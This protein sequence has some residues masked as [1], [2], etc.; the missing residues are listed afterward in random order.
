MCEG[1]LDMVWGDM[2]VDSIEKDMDVVDYD[3]C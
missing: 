2:V 3:G 1:L